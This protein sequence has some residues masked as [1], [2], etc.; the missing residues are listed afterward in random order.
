[1]D[2]G[3]LLRNV[4]ARIDDLVEV[5]PGR[6]VIDQFER[7]DLEHPVAEHGLKAGR[8]RIEKDRAAHAGSV[9]IRRRIWRSA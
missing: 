9:P 1:M 4:P 5:A 2:A 7:R 6:Q 8:L 3:G